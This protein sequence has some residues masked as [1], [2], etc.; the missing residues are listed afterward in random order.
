[1]QISIVIPTLNEERNIQRLM[2]YLK[3]LPH[4]VYLKEVIVSDGGS[5]D[6][7]VAV[8][9]KA[10]A[11]VLQAPSR[12]RAVQMNHGAAQSTGDMLYFVHADVIPPKTCLLDIVEATQEGHCMGCFA[13]DFDSRATLLRVNAFLTT[14]KWL[15]SG[16]G[17]QTFYI[18]KKVFKELGCFDEKLPIMEDFDF[19]KRAKKKY[20]FHLIPK[21][22]IV[23]ARKYEQ[24]SYLKV[25]IA[26][27]LVFSL[28]KMGVSPHKLATW[29]R[30]LLFK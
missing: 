21:K 9:K 10:G 13:Y 26:N 5:T 11:R 28:F 23:S 22:V 12:G 16:G 4:Q 1:M 3:G 19:V 27:V 20:P 15:A 24:N 8:A 29:Y 7:T 14:F 25:Q 17:D 2:P 18:P 30:Q 6:N